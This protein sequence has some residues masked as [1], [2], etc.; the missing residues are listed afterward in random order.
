MCKYLSVIFNGN[1][2]W[3]VYIEM[4]KVKVYGTFISV[5]SVFK[6]ERLSAAIAWSLIMCVITYAYLPWE[7][8]FKL[9]HVQNNVL[10]TNGNFLS[11][12]IRVF[13]NAL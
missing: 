12:K 6:N 8:L 2:V 5:Y 1:V 7:L 11:G 9:L 10:R 4:I 3:C 13:S